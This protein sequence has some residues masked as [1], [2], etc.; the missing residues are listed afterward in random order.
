L[1]AHPNASFLLLLPL[2]KKG[3]ISTKRGKISIVDFYQQK[4]VF[5]LRIRHRIKKIE[6]IDSESY[7]VN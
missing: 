4:E 5:V 7:T 2:N 1:D 3:I 6:K